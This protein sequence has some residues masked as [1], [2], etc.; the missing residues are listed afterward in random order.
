MQINF[1]INRIY[2]HRMD[3]E[4]AILIPMFIKFQKDFFLYAILGQD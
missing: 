2:K 3:V 1:I 4:T